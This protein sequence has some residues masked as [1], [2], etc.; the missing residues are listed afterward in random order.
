MVESIKQ[1]A[2]W[3]SLRGNVWQCGTMYG[4][5]SNVYQCG[6]MYGSVGNVGQC[7]ALY[8]SDWQFGATFGVVGYVAL[9][10]WK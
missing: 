7:G 10:V 6:A 4:G 8:E 5:M 3:R 2:Q 1:Y 9:P